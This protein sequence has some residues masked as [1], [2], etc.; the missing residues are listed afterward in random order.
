MKVNRD[1]IRKLVDRCIY[2]EVSAW[3]ELI[4]FLTP[5]L[6][7][8]IK[9]RFAR[10]GHR[11]Q[12]S[13]I[14]NLMQ[15]ILLSIWEKDKL[16]TIKDKEKV[17]PWIYALSSH[18]ASNYLRRGSLRGPANV[19]FPTDLLASKCPTPSE[20]L[21]SKF[22]GADID[23]ALSSLNYQEQLIIKLSLLCNKKFKDISS[24][25]NIP[26][27][28]VLVYAGRARMKLRAELKKYKKNM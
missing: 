12:K 24:I 9:N 23:D 7:S 27:G 25:L 10:S 18:A 5:Y 20:E 8:S 11:Y 4:R 17:I 28:T 2:G 19:D 22:I 1:Y 21:N 16:H 14:D 6:T 15:D 13:D 3:D 26:I